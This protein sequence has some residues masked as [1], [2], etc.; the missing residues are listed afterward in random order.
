M[1]VW[2]F[3]IRV[4]LMRV[5]RRKPGANFCMGGCDPDRA[6][7]PTAVDKRSGQ[8][9]RQVVHDLTS[10]DGWFAMVP[11]VGRQRSELAQGC[12]CSGHL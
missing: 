12:E 4:N 5:R 1:I 11:G 2:I 6:L 10:C 3:G 8:V 7:Q 9:L